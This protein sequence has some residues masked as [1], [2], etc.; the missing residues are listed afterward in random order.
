[1]LHAFETTDVAMI[2]LML[3]V[4]VAFVAIQFSP[5]NDGRDPEH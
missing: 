5:R 4:V 1:M 2:I 3:L